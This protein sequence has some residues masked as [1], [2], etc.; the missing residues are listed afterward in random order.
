MRGWFQQ[1]I[2]HSDAAKKGWSRRSRRIAKARKT[3]KKVRQEDEARIFFD[4]ELEKFESR[5]AKLLGIRRPL[6]DDELVSRLLRADLKLGKVIPKDRELTHVMEL[7][8]NKK[9][10]RWEM[11]EVTKIAKRRLRTS[12]GR[13][14]FYF[15]PEE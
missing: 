13:K 14:D 7:K 10:E 11:V 4:T 15:V 9:K 3:L 8:W 5:W 2:R 6:A 1:R 12:K